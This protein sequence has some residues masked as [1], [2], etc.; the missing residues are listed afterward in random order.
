MSEKTCTRCRDAWPADTEFFRP[1]PRPGNP[2]RL[3]PWC[4]ACEL[5]QKQEARQRAKEPTHG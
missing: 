4:R 1:Q 2:D 3:A 5:E